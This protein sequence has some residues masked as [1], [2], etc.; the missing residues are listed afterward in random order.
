VWGLS[1]TG[2]EISVNDIFNW[3]LTAL[4]YLYRTHKYIYSRITSTMNQVWGQNWSEIAS[5]TSDIDELCICTTGEFS[6]NWHTCVLYDNE[7]ILMLT[8]PQNIYC[9]FMFQTITHSTSTKY[10]DSTDFRYRLDCNTFPLRLQIFT[11]VAMKNAAFWDVGTQFIPHKK[12]I[13]SPLQSPTS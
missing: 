7:A 10:S 2:A 4:Q 5:I 9:H 12:H 6:S 8:F 1:T 13:R 11:A 3:R